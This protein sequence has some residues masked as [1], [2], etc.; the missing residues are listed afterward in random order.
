MLKKC[1]ICNEEKKLTEFRKDKCQTKGYQHL[2]KVCARARSN[3][4]YQKYKETILTRNKKRAEKV[5]QYIREYK[6]NNAC[7]VCGEK[8]IVC[9]D[10]HHLDPSQ[11]NFQ[12]SSVY[13]QSIETVKCEIEKCILVCKNCHAKIH[14]GLIIL[15]YS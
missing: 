12:L 4:H 13:T 9:L 7:T 5:L 10:F 6:Q 2:C 8:E 3:A 14:A 11:K 1:C 15:N